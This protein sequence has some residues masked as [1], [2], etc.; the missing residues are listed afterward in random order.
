SIH[1]VDLSE[2]NVLNTR[3]VCEELGFSDVTVEQGNA[4]N[5][6]FPDAFFDFVFSDGVIMITMDTHRALR[7]LVRVLAPGG[8]LFVGVYGYGGLW[9]KVIHPF[10][11][12][13]GRIIP[14]RWAEAFVNATGLLKSQ[15]NS[16]LDWFYAP[17][18]NSY[19]TATVLGWFRD[20]G[21]DHAV[22]IQ[23]PKWF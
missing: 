19:S 15:E 6:P 4:L 21:F 3:R 17:I 11:R 10:G 2:P 20:S 18:Q 16:L 12:L 7:E 22:N 9:G 23:S 13:L 1:A 14:L 5:L 8:Y